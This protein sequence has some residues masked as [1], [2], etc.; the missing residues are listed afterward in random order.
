MSGLTFTSRC[1][2]V[3]K[4]GNRDVCARYRLHQKVCPICVA[5]TTKPGS[6]FL[7][8]KKDLN[9]LCKDKPLNPNFVVYAT[10]KNGTEA[11]ITNEKERNQIIKAKQERAAKRFAKLEEEAIDNF[12]QQLHENQ[13]D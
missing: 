2:F 3:M 8:D 6:H 9:R 1:G 7:V 13:Q 11:K 4:G 5:S 12:Y 10:G